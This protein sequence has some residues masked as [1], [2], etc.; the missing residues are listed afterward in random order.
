[1]SARPKARFRATVD[2]VEGELAVLELPAGGDL[3]IPVNLLP[4]G[5]GDGAVLDFTVERDL[6]E[7]RRRRDDIA[8]LQARLLARNGPPKS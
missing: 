5:L 8:D 1:M 2:R 6:A 3:V 4:A 7:E